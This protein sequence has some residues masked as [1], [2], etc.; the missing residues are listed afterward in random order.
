MAGLPEFICR[1]ENRRVDGTVITE[2]RRSLDLSTVG[3]QTR[4][5]PRAGEG[6]KLARQAR[7]RSNP[8]RATGSSGTRVRQHQPYNRHRSFP[9]RQD[10]GSARE[11]HLPQARTVDQVS[12]D[13]IRLPTRTRVAGETNSLGSTQ[14]NCPSVPATLRRSG[15]AGGIRWSR[16]EVTR[17]RWPTRI[18]RHGDHYGLPGLRTGTNGTNGANQ[19][20]TRCGGRSCRQ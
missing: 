12:G 14:P 15:Q 8:S 4:P 17:V 19:C 5:R 10:G 2:R 18:A 16:P 1:A 6:P 11:Q 13:C 20:D 9:Q 7:Q 3:R